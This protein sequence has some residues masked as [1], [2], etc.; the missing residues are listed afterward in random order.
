MVL[1]NTAQMEDNTPLFQA[2]NRNNKQPN[3][4]PKSL[5]YILYMQTYLLASYSQLIEN[6]L[7]ICLISGLLSKVSKPNDLFIAAWPYFPRQH[8][9][10]C[11]KTSCCYSYM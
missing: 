1:Y 3:N 9:K 7:R 4:N 6:F 11:N 2:N 10:Q 5:I 8:M